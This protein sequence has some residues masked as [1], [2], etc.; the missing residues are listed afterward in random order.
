MHSSKKKNQIQLLSAVAFQEQFTKD[1]RLEPAKKDN[2][3]YKINL[4]IHLY[5]FKQ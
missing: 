2:G 4:G 1:I 3:K 5:I